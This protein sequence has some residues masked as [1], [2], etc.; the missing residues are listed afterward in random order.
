MTMRICTGA[1]RRPYQQS[2]AICGDFL[3]LSDMHD[4]AA[5]QVTLDDSHHLNGSFQESG[6]MRFSYA[7]LRDFLVGPIRTDA[8][9]STW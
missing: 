1:V 7:E 5:F 6:R 3:P 8:Y 2:P 4:P 9:D